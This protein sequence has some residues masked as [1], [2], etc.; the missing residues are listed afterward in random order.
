MSDDFESTGT[1]LGTTIKRFQRMAARQRA[2]GWMCYMCLFVI[3]SFA[4]M[5]FYV[6]IWRS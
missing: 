4:F 2:G 1:L 3:A 5:L 6:K